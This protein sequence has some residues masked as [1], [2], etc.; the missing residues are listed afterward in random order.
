MKGSEALEV[1]GIVII[2]L[3][4]LTIFL[5]GIFPKFVRIVSETIALTS[6]NYVAENLG[7]FLTLSAAEPYKIVIDFQIFGERETGFET[8]I[9]YLIK[10]QK[11]SLD[12]NP[13]FKLPL[14]SKGHASTRFAAPFKDFVIK[15]AKH[16][17]IVKS[18]E[19][20]EEKYE[21]F[22]VE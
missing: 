9:S 6:S 13:N 12:V 1:L 19:N 11:R 18:F 7:S 15:D 17:R 5:L 21:V 8:G 22:E 14:M 10:S 20:G 16:L 3:A 4:F 2:A